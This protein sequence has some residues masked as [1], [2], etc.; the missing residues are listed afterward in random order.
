MEYFYHH[1]TLFVHSVCVYVYIYIGEIVK[2][3]DSKN[4]KKHIHDEIVLKLYTPPFEC[5]ITH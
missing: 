2:T 3:A 4:D 1:I 5:T